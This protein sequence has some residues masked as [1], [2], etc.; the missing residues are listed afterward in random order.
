MSCSPRRPITSRCCGACGTAGR[1]TPRSATSPPGGS[2]TG[3]SCTTST[4]RA[5][6]SRV[7]GPSI[8]PR[9]PQGQP[10]VAAL[11]HGGACLPADRRAAPTSASSRRTTPRRR[12]TSSAEIGGAAT[13]RRSAAGNTLHIF[14]RPGGVPR[15]TTAEGGQARRRRLDDLRRH[16]I[17][18]ATPTIFVGTPASWPICCRSGTPAGLSGFRLR[19]GRAAP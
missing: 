17:S 16:R 15:R 7:K 8:T 10:V 3:T 4:S 2:S 1:T 18:A 14:G 6:G 11:G 9:P 12:R 13:G 19:P 5:A